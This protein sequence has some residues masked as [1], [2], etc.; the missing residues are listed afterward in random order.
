MNLTSAAK[1]LSLKKV[2]ITTNALNFK[3][4][5]MAK[6]NASFWPHAKTQRRQGF[7]SCLN[8]NSLRLSSFA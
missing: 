8:Q 5:K 3:I 1:V 6:V 4:I 7:F 2:L